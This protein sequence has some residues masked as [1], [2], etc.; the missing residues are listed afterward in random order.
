[1]I[2]L[3]LFVTAVIFDLLYL[4]TGNDLFPVVAFWDIALGILGGL[5]AALFG[6][7]DWLHVP[8]GTRAKAV[9]LYHGLGNVVVV[10]LFALSWFLRRDNPNYAPATLDMVLSYLGIG[11]GAVTAW[12]GGELV[13]R[14]GIGVDPGAN[15]DAPN[16]LTGQP[17]SGGRAS[18][19]R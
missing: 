6:F 14:L 18:T 13:D 11:L 7:W 1:V 3:G 17:A 8:A 10:L 5:L 9:G 4:A 2:P 19:R 16:S 12:L 15:P